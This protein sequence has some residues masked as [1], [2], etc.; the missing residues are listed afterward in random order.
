MEPCRRFRCQ[1][2]CELDQI[3]QIRQTRIQN[4]RFASPIIK[5]DAYLVAYRILVWRL[6]RGINDLKH[7]RR[8]TR[9]DRM[10]SRKGPD[11]RGLVKRPEPATRV[12]G[13][14][15]SESRLC[16]ALSISTLNFNSQ[17]SFCPRLGCAPYRLSLRK[18][19]VSDEYND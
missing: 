5:G 15:R 16:G 9:G 6:S 12:S 4:K 17:P 3:R 19:T 14:F 2:A 8:D 18:S 7:S 11:N 10:S 1:R 13:Y